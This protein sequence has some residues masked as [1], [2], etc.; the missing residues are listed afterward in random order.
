[1]CMT[2]HPSSLS[3]R[4]APALLHQRGERAGRG[5]SLTE[6]DSSFVGGAVAA[7]FFALLCFA[8]E[9][10][11]AASDPVSPKLVS[12]RMAP[13]TA[14][15]WGPQSAQRFLVLGK[16]S[17]GLE[18]DITSSARFSTASTESIQVDASGRGF[19][20]FGWRDGS[21]S[22]DQRSLRRIQGRRP[23][24]SDRAQAEFRSGHRLNPDLAG[25]QRQ[26]MPRRGRGQRRVQ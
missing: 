12:L 22:G 6:N 26:Q 5:A 19:S 2:P 18:R 7:F 4:V 9:Q 10:L 14:T 15:L 3:P 16:Y 24:I 1:M 11:A 25:L 21:E 20:S 13:E 23:G 8:A 17:D